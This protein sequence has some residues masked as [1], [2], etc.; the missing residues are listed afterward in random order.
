MTAN[1]YAKWTLLLCAA[2]LFLAGCGGGDS[3]V[4]QGTHDMLQIDLDAALA[5]LAEE[6][7]ARRDAEA[8][9][10]TARLTV[11]T[12][13]TQIGAAT[14]TA[15]DSDRASLHARLNAATARVAT[16]TA[17]IG[18][19]ADSQSLRGM[20]E[21]EKVKVTRLTAE[22]QAA[23]TSLTTLRGQLTTAQ[24]AVA[25]AQQQAAQQVQAAQQQAAQQQQQLQQQLTEAEQAELNA[26][27]SAYIAAINGGGT[28]RMGVTVTHAVGSTLM[29]NPNGNF[30]TGSG[31]PAISGFT[32]RTYTRQVGVS[33]EQ[34]LYLY[35]NI[36]GPARR[37]AFWKEYG[38]TETGASGMTA[39][40]PTPTGTPRFILNPM[41]STT[42][43]GVQVAGTYDGVS[44]TY[45]CTTGGCIGDTSGITLANFITTDSS[46]R[47]FA[48]GNTWDFTPTSINSVVSQMADTEH[49]YFGIWVEEPIVASAMHMYQH[50][51]GGSD[52]YTT[53]GVAG[54]PGT[55]RFS[56]GAVGK[57][58]TRNQVGENAR[59]GTFTADANFTATFGASP[60]LEGRITNFR[61]GSQTLTGWN[62]Y[63]G[64][65]N[66]V[67]MA[68]TGGAVTGATASA[69][70]GGIPATGTWDATLHGTMNNNLG[71]DPTATPNPRNLTMYPLA[72]YPVADLAGVVGNFDASSTSTITPTGGNPLPTA[73][74]AGAFGATP[75]N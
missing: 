67:P 11:T 70:I 65:A 26:R 5:Q 13:E 62:V 56:G 34:T 59:I 38:L 42:A 66:N 36:Q 31:A 9:L 72:R 45:A 16:L 50:I 19:A 35:T 57:Y 49:L 28:E 55:A 6:E 29:I 39:N 64:D 54:L 68:F 58:V 27:A 21:A 14:D 2:A 74:L 46:G 40:N 10:A 32:A 12:L 17:E 8:A 61:D 41:D 51:M 44:G 22:L 4:D 18:T 73:A 71:H 20:L 30:E 3:G 52:P 43:T 23:N 48:T 33:G 25:T 7:E 75:S 60:T 47:S 24:Q 63:L 69:L 37:R 15:D 53:V 1:R